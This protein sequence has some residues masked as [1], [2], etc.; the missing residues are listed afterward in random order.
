MTTEGLARWQRQQRMAIRLL[1]GARVA[2]VVAGGF[3][4]WLLAWAVT[5]PGP[6]VAAVL[7]DV[8][9]W[10]TVDPPP[11][12]TIAW[13]ESRFLV[14]AA[15][16]AAKPAAGVV[17]ETASAWRLLGVD[18][19]G[20]PPRALLKETSKDGGRAVWVTAGD[21]LQ[22]M[23]VTTVEAGRVVVRGPEGDRELRL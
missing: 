19:G 1:V 13:P 21:Q 23:T 5:R 11:P 17:V 3:A 15:P 10:E 4:I 12:V 20:T 18:A 8:P 2:A 22:G 14:P 6:S 7:P 9:A 16:S